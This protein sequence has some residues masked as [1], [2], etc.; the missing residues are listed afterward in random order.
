MFQNAIGKK[1]AIIKDKN[2]NDWDTKAGKI[3]TGKIIPT[4]KLFEK[5]GAGN[6][7]NPPT[8]PIIIDIYAVFSSNFLL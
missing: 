3:S 4:S 5:S 2:N 1:V 8:N 6:K 7:R